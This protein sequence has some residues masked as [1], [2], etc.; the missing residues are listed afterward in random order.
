[1]TQVVIL[2]GKHLKLNIMKTKKN[3]T[4]NWATALIVIVA[5]IERILGVL[6]ELGLQPEDVK[7]IE[8]IGLILLAVIQFFRTKN[9][10]TEE[11][12]ISKTKEVE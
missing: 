10:L 8:E 7:R 6:P 12:V 2:N 3:K 9:T 1:M 11:T 5:I 4:I